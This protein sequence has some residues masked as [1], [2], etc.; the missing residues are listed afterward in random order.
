LDIGTIRIQWG[1]IVNNVDSIQSVSLPVAFLDA[2][3][4]LTFGQNAAW[5]SADTAIRPWSWD[6]KSA[7]GFTIDRD[8]DVTGTALVDWIAIGAKP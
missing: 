6:S 4:V 1:T 2:T 3:Y 7:T 8:D 5:T